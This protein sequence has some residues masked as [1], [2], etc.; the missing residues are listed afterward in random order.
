VTGALWPGA[1]VGV[2]AGLKLDSTSPRIA[3]AATRLTDARYGALGVLGQGRHPSNFVHI[4]SFSIGP[5]PSRWHT[6]DL[7]GY[8]CRPSDPATGSR[9]E[10]C[11]GSA[12]LCGNWEAEHTQNLTFGRGTDHRRYL[13]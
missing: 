8:R 10:S 12:S 5:A 3:D 4:G 13:A 1:V 7:T 11:S 6:V 2:P 9:S